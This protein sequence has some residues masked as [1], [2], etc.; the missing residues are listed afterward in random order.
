MTNKIIF[1]VVSCGTA[2]R[3]PRMLRSL[4]RLMGYLRL[5]RA[6]L[7]LSFGIE[8]CAFSLF[9]VVAAIIRV[10]CLGATSLRSVVKQCSRYFSMEKPIVF[11]YYACAVWPYFQKFTL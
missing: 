5:G 8:F 3:R 1:G 6:R 9:P 4:N 11:Q 2:P 7:P 10:Q